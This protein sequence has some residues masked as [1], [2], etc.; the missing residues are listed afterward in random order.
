MIK[1]DGIQYEHTFAYVLFK[2]ELGN[3]IKIPISKD[4]ATNISLHL[5][6]LSTVDRTIVERGNDEHTE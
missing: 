3:Q 6:R 2:N 4:S 5:D 1:Y